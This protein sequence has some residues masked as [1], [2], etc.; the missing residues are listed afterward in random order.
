VNLSLCSY[1]FHRKLE[2]GQHDVFQYIADCQALGCTLLDLWNGHLPTLLDQP[3]CVGG[4]ALA[5]V[6]APPDTTAA[7]E[8]PPSRDWLLL[9][10]ETAFLDEVRAAADAAGLPMGCLAVDGAHLYEPTVEARALHHRR[11]TRWC[12]I[13]ARLGARQIRIDSGG[14]ED[15]PDEVFALIV[16]GYQDLL[17][18]AGRLGLEVVMENHWGASRIPANVVQILEAVPDLGLLFDT[19]NWPPG[20]HEAAWAQCARFATATHI[21]TRA[22]DGDG[23]ETTWNIPL[24]VSYLRAAGYDGSWGIESVPAEGDEFEAARRSLELVRRLAGDRPAAGE[25]A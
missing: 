12:Q 4:R 2:A 20:Q 15:M 23:N 11:A 10:E 1:S 21:K 17:G 14:P 22:F 13:A 7:A 16:A 25:A 8:A 9:P 6:P 3:G 24:A 19:G 18:R 5:A